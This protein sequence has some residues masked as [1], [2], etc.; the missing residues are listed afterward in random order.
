MHSRILTLDSHCDTPMHFHKGIHIARRCP[1]VCVDLH[2]MSEGGLDAAV[3]AAYL[4]QRSRT[5]QALRAATAY[6]DTLLEQIRQQV[7]SSVGVALAQSA[8]GVYQQ[9]SYGRRAI[10]LG[11][12]HG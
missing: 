12:E 1:E 4:P 7:R 10:V 6:A 5:E 3:M 11:S 8:K 2:K 9:Q